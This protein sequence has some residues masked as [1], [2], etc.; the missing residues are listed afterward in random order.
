[1]NSGN[2]TL[3][4]SRMVAPGPTP[5]FDWCTNEFLSLINNYRKK[6]N[7]KKIKKS[8]LFMEIKNRCGHSFTHVRPPMNLW[9]EPRDGN[10]ADRS[11]IVGAPARSAQW[12]S[13][14]VHCLA[15]HVG[16]TYTAPPQ[17]SA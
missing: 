13:S 8:F 11:R 14:P 5:C 12:K 7:L 9:F 6:L 15:P 16:A 2:G 10:G 4:R 17:G 3:S 1:M